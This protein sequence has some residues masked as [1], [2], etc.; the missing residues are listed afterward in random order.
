MYVQAVPD[1]NHILTT[2]TDGVGTLFLWGEVEEWIVLITMSIPAIWP[3]FR[4]STSRFVKSS[5]SR[6]N[7]RGYNSNCNCN[8]RCHS[9]QP[10]SPSVVSDQ[11]P[12]SRLPLVTTT[13][14]VSS[15]KGG[16]TA[17]V[18]VPVSSESSSR[19]S[20]EKVP[21]LGKGKDAQ[22]WV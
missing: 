14:S 7:R 17:P 6:S 8:C 1:N 11:S 22:S 18:A 5:L 3:L 4:P 2:P 10:Q 15:I 19:G 16:R 13:I 12:G 9:N 20:D 21:P